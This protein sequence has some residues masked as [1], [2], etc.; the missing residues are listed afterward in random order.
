MI[1]VV[2]VGAGGHCK[3]TIEVIE[4]NSDMYKIT[5]ILD[6][7]FTGIICGYPI[8]GNDDL[9]EE[10]VK[11]NYFIITVGSI[12]SA[13]I[14]E[15]IEKKIVKENGKILSI[16]SKNA[17]VSKRAIIGY[18]TVVFN[19]SHVNADCRV[20]NNCILNTACNIEHDC[21][22]GDFVH[23]STGAMINGGCSI[24]NRCFIGS[25][26]TIMNGISISDDV[27]VGAGSVVV[28]NIIDSGVYV[29]N[30]A[31]KIQ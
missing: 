2:L 12:K 5:G 20:G 16:V 1:S 22:I 25:N 21:I 24:G 23:V 7:N 8:L 29:G 4:S 9:I 18:G 14:R 27:I 13:K 15:N 31:K 26:A 3:S 10:L 11:E 19:N 17:I 30:P 6:S 28:K